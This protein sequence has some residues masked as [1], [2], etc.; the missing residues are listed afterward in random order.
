MLKI[1]KDILFVLKLVHCACIT[2]ICGMDQ[3]ITKQKKIEFLYQF[4][5]WMENPNFIKKLR[6]H[7][8]I[9]I[10]LLDLQKCLRIFFQLLG[11]NQKKRNIL[12]KNI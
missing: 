6:V 7:T 10:N 8:L 12:S 2:V 4:I 3:A 11:L 9:I 1:I 5:L